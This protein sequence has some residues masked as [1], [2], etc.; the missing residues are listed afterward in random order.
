LP[1]KTNISRE[2]LKLFKD[3]MK[4]ELTL[5]ERNYKLTTTYKLTDNSNIKKESS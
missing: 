2:R 3:K 5:V 4:K 1:K